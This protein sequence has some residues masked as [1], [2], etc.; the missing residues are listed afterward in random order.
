MGRFLNLNAPCFSRR[1]RCLL[2][3][4]WFLWGLI[5]GAVLS[6]AANS[7]ASLIPAA[8][9]R[10]GSIS[11]LL[12]VVALPFLMSFFAAW[13]QWPWLLYP[14]AFFKAFLVSFL[15]LGVLCAYGSAG[16]LIRLLLLFSECC[17]LPLLILC[18]IRLLSGQGRR[19]LPAASAV[20]TASL[21]GSFDY[22]I[23]SPFLARVLS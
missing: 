3:A 20:F 16:W 7:I 6:A 11:G 18:W 23:V 2:L 12:T 10:P 9:I 22:C 1:N 21:I 5:S 14:I 17:T 13:I 19:L 15:G 4:L 8:V